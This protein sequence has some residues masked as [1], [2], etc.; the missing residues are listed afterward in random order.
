MPFRGEREKR[1]LSRPR[2]VLQRRERRRGSSL[3]LIMPVRKKRRRR[4][5]L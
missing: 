3:G 4:G 1:E 5:V 2:Y